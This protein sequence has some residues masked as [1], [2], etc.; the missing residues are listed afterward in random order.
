MALALRI[1]LLVGAL[2][3]MGAKLAHAQDASGGTFSTIQGA[4]SACQADANPGHFGQG[5]PTY[6]LSATC[7]K[8]HPAYGDVYGPN[9]IVGCMNRTYDTCHYTK[10]FGYTTGCAAG[11]TFNQSTGQ[12]DNPAADSACAAKG[13]M[14]GVAKN[15]ASAG[16][17]CVGGCSY[18]QSAG[19]GGTGPDGKYN[20]NGTFTNLGS[21]CTPGAGT[22]FQ[23]VGA[24]PAEKA[25]SCVPIGSLSQC[26]NP[27]TNKM[28]A[29]TPRG[30]KACWSISENN[31]KISPD[32]KEALAKAVSPTVPAAPPTLVNAETSTSTTNTQ[33]APGA[34]P[35]TIIN[36]IVYSNTTGQ[37]GTGDTGS[38]SDGSSTG[39]DPATTGT[40]SGGGF[41]TGDSANLAAVKVAAES[42]ATSLDAIEAALG[43]ET[44][45]YARGDDGMA[46]SGV[47]AGHNEET[48]Y[49]ASGLDQSGMGFGSSC[50]VIPPLT[51]LGSEVSFDTS[52]FCQFMTAAGYLVFLFAALGCLRIIGGQT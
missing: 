42:S 50:P 9:K 48:E 22:T 35:T 14:N 52:L 20:R 45:P 8:G 28:C 34:S 16:N 31:T 46:A 33:T 37:A 29:I 23:A 51:I 2:F 7:H 10:T 36:N 39:S 32:Q 27:S 26:F 18:F 25:E 6:F 1:V 43:P 11:E 44:D 49:G 4:W 3:F 24:T 19:I 12:C 15:V 47:A 40:T 38:G 30:A 21:A 5:T 41:G 13:N 17:L